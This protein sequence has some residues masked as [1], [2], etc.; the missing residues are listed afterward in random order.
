[1]LYLSSNI[2][3]T[4]ENDFLKFNKGSSYIILLF[5]CYENL[6]S[7]RTI[8]F[9]VNMRENVAFQFTTIMYFSD[10]QKFE[11]K[12]TTKWC[13]KKTWLQ[14]PLHL[15]H[16]PSLMTWQKKLGFQNLEGF[17]KSAKLLQIFA[18]A[19]EKSFMLVA[20]KVTD[21]S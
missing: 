17:R 4:C 10:F 16:F 21:F 18:D 14:R 5:C 9:C 2:S 19:S 15:K 3:V 13:Q 8:Q 12:V 7:I 20:V 6:R 11:F 1:M